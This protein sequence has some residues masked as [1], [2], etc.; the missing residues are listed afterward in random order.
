MSDSNRLS[1]L[2]V[3]ESTFGVTPSTPAMGAMRFTSE[4]LRQETQTTTSN[5]INAT[6][7]R[8]DVVRTDASAAGD[9]GWELFAPSG[10]TPNNPINQNDAMFQAALL[11]SA[12]TAA[13]TVTGTTLSA[14]VSDNSF[15]DSA[16]GFGSITVGSWVR[17]TGFSIAS[18]NG[19]F[20]VLSKPNA[21]KIIV[22]GLNAV[23]NE[24]AG[25]SRTILQFP[26]I[27]NGTTFRSFTIEK[28]FLDLTNEFAYLRGLA[29]NSMSLNYQKGS[30]VTGSFGTIG[31]RE[32]SGTATLANSVVAALTTDVLNTVDDQLYFAENMI[33]GANDFDITAFSFQLNN[34]LR[35][36]TECGTLGAVS[37]GVGSV[38][39][40]GSV[41]AYFKN[42]TI[43]DRYLNFA[44]SSLHLVLQR[45]G[46]TGGWIFDLP[47][48][49]FTNGQRVGGGL[50]QDIMAELQFT[51][52]RNSTEDKTIRIAR[53]V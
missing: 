18:N 14:S 25:T 49:K 27:T 10:A 51:A 26:E 21:G 19:I 22:G 32:T 48:V 52:F 38:D 23:A 6:R 4:S 24:T 34:N 53:M 42:K 41:T 28:R 39:I 29:I 46:T 50:N 7:Q 30:I 1:L 16:N 3:E 12:W 2:F 31:T 37:M 8:T 20:K 44:N 15:N 35:A 33:A 11:S 36:Q 13:V 47:R 40:T 5:E 43:L 45:N 9:I 17:V